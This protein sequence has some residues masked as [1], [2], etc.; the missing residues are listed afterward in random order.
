MMCGGIGT[1]SEANEEVQSVVDQVKSAAETKTGKQFAVFTAKKY[2]T[3]VVAGMNYFVKVHV[4][5]DSYVHVRV[6][7]PLPGQGELQLHSVQEG[8]QHT[9]PITYF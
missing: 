2:T 1:E 3:Q 5:D 8:K 7:M 6:Y 9:D 4:G